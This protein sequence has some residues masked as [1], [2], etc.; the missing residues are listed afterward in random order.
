MI[1]LIFFP[2]RAKKIKKAEI[3]PR[4]VPVTP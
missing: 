2:R 3:P 1:S 4:T